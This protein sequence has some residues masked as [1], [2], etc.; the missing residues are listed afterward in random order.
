MDG[1]RNHVVVAR[2]YDELE[3]TFV[4]FKNEIPL[5]IERLLAEYCS[6][7]GYVLGPEGVVPRVFEGEGHHLVVCEIFNPP[8]ERVEVSFGPN[9]GGS[10]GIFVDQ[11]GELDVPSHCLQIVGCVQSLDFMGFLIAGELR[12]RK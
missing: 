6:G 10:R 2:G 3:R 8:P 7:G 12:R 11:D 4:P 9:D 5:E 1:V